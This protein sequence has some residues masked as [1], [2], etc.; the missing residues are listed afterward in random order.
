MASWARGT[1]RDRLVARH[2][3]RRHGSARVSKLT[4]MAAPRAARAATIGLFFVNGALWSNVIPRLPEI[5]DRLHLGNGTFGLAIGTIG[6][7]A[8]A[9]GLFA[10]FLI[11]L[12]SPGRLA[13]GCGI[14]LCCAVFLVA[15]AP[16]AVVLVPA[17]F[18]V[19]AFDSV[20][21]V[22]MNTHGM[23]VQRRYGRS[24]INSFHGWWSVGAVV[25]G[26]MG[27]AAAAVGLPVAPHIAIA[28]GL[29]G[30][31]VFSCGRGLLPVAEMVEQAPTHEHG[32]A[33]AYRA[34]IRTLAVLC[35]MLL[36]AAVMED[37]PGSWSAIY[38]RDVLHTSAGAAGLG[39]VGFASAMM[40][41]RFLADRLVVRFGPVRVVRVGTAA[42]AIGLA[43]GLVVAQPVVAVVGFVVL[44][45]GISTVFPLVFAASAEKP[46]IRTGAG[47]AVT[48]FTARAGF[49]VAPPAVGAVATGISLP[50]GVGLASIAALLVS[51][52]AG[53]LSTA[54]E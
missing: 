5:R 24:I 2:P 15:L 22:S 45:F 8:L 6:L 52:L 54:S 47:I 13:V 29:F 38:L 46:G 25:G 42:G 3:D 21:D 31:V 36:L 4:A 50:V 35:V 48:S 16:S 32:R 11:H 33:T 7:G 39:Y 9:A 37:V 26:L 34:V 49:M 19:G 27:S 41:G 20:M 12:L 40:V 28:S 1:S 44:G 23:H 51:T 53:A 10:G 18:M 30:I 14:G 43:V 17:L